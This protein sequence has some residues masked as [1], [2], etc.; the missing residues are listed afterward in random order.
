MANTFDEEAK[1]LTKVSPIKNDYLV[2]QTLE[3]ELRESK[4][5]FPLLDDRVKSLSNNPQSSHHG[6]QR[7]IFKVMLMCFP[8]DIKNKFA[9]E[10]DQIQDLDSINPG[11]TFLLVNAQMYFSPEDFK[12]LIL[13]LK[14]DGETVFEDVRFFDDLKT[15]T[16]VTVLESKD[17]FMV[18]SSGTSTIKDWM[19][20]LK[21]SSQVQAE[22]TYHLGFYESFKSVE[23]KIKEYINSKV[24]KKVIFT[25]HS[26]GGALSQIFL[27]KSLFEENFLSISRIESVVTWASPRVFGSN[28]SKKL[29]DKIRSENINFVRIV[30]SK[31]LVP[32]LPFQALDYLS[33]M[34]A[35]ERVSKTEWREEKEK[36]K[37]SY[38][39]F[40]NELSALSWNHMGPL[41]FSFH[42]PELEEEF[43]IS[44]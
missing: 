21:F 43:N 29:E 7:E 13:S 35:S 4:H 20:N 18:M 23:K 27:A 25:G 2:P 12:S 10:F 44:K 36:D 24:Q 3:V 38:Y 19:G 40:I 6:S 28:L 5:C 33:V 1:F 34:E 42:R 41:Y 11:L 31:D 32:H 16:Q 30:N 17:H 15:D 22:G 39:H 9:L 37:R 26:L 14:N 8:Q